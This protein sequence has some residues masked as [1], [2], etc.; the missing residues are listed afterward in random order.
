MVPGDAANFVLTLFTPPSGDA[1]NF[2]LSDEVLSPF[3]LGFQAYGK[4]GRPE[5]SDPLGVYG[6]YQRRMLKNGKGYIKMK[7]YTPTNPQTVPQQAN[8]TKFAD[9][10]AAWMALTSEQKSAY[11]KRAKKRGKHPWGLFIREYYQSH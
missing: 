8:R 11:T 10:M 2:E 5:W 3:F 7:F 6:I 4:L 1:V 9:A